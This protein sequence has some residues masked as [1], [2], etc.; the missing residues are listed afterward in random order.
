MS[1]INCQL[2][3][4]VLAVLIRLKKTRQLSRKNMIH[5]YSYMWTLDKATASLSA[6]RPKKIM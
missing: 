3:V 4:C 6:A 1:I 5:L 2:I